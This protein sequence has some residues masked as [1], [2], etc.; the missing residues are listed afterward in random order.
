MADEEDLVTDDEETEDSEL[1]ASSDDEEEESSDEEESS[2]SESSDGKPAAKRG[3]PAKEPP[4][5]K[6]WRLE[7]TSPEGLRVTLGRY[8]NKEEADPDLER[9]EE[10]GFYQKLKIIKAKEE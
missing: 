7:G 4:P 9:L 8:V 10:D 5:P 6:L 1:E 2:E 3:R